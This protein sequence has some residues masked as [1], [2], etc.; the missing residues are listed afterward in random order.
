MKATNS[1]SFKSVPLP[2]SDF[3]GS[4][5]KN[6][7]N[8]LY[9]RISTSTFLKTALASFSSNPPNPTFEGSFL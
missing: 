6:M 4:A 8:F 7:R 3:K 5:C 1:S 9:C 2:K